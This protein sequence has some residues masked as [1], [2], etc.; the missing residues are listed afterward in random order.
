[1]PWPLLTNPP[2]PLSPPPT[3]TP[4]I[5]LWKRVEGA[6]GRTG[7]PSFLLEGVLGELQAATSRHLAHLAAG[8]TLEL[9]ATSSRKGALRAFASSSSSSSRMVAGN[10]SRDPTRSDSEEGDQEGGGGGSA[11]LGISSSSSR[12]LTSVAAASAFDAAG[13]ST[14]ESMD[15]DEEEASSSNS[16]NSGGKKGVRKGPKAV[17]T[18]EE[19]SKVV[20][21]QGMFLS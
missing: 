14:T 2:F 10:S 18:K 1:M 15:S 9:S 17:G 20:R 4:Q 5:A 12:V 19:I 7:I 6:F 16:G 11:A 8:M 21:V 13:G 3:H